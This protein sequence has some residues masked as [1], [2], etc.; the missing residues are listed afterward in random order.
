MKSLQKQKRVGRHSPNQPLKEGIYY[1]PCVS[2]LSL[3]SLFAV[4]VEES[5]DLLDKEAL[6][7]LDCEDF[8]P[9]VE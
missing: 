6:E 8:G 9:L 4:V 1:S 7:A 2:V 3:L 5:E